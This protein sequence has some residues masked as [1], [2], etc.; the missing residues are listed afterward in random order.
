MCRPGARKYEVLTTRGEAEVEKERQEL[1]GSGDTLMGKLR[2][3]MGCWPSTHLA[4][5]EDKLWYIRVRRAFL[6]GQQHVR[7]LVAL[8]AVMGVNASVKVW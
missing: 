7:Q 5:S 8:C 3:R 4:T 6:F 1:L 2:R